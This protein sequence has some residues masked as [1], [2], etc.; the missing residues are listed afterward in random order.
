MAA[1]IVESTERMTDENMANEAYIKRQFAILD[2]L[3]TD[4]MN[5]CL[6]DPKRE[7]AMLVKTIRQNTQPRDTAQNMELPY[8]Q[9]CQDSIT[10]YAITGQEKCLMDAIQLDVVTQKLAESQEYSFVFEVVM[11]GIKHDC[12]MKYV[13][14]KDSPYILMGFRVIDA[15]LATEKQ[16]KDKL[17]EE[18]VIAK[19][20]TRQDKAIIRRS[21]EELR[22]ERMFLDVLCMDYASVYFFD[23]KNDTL[24]V[25]KVGA[26][27]NAA[28]LLGVQARKE[29]VIR[30]K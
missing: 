1:E 6:V 26:G 7:T 14:L 19:Q 2:A 8:Y 17:A 25:L 15:L 23:I 24:E 10:R 20:K 16:Q 4:Y 18:A 9:M 3:G 21:A 11:D 12:Q 28:Q 13:W 27:L 30:K 5:I 29:S 22:K